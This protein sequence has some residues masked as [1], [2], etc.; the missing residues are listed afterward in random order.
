MS[1][2][3]DITGR[4]GIGR[5]QFAR[6]MGGWLAR[7]YSVRTS[8]QPTYSRSRRRVLPVEFPVRTGCVVAMSGALLGFSAAIATG[9]SDRLFFGTAVA[10]T[11][12]VRVRRRELFGAR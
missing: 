12:R 3:I 9:V 11:A 10:V 7:R 4:V 1:R 5:V 2:V 6:C 8:L